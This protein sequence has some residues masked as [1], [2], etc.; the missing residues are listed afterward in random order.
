MSQT[1]EMIAD[2]PEAPATADPRPIRVGFVLHAMHVAGAEVLVVETIRRLGDRISPTVFCLDD[3]GA[4]GEGLRRDGVEVLELGRRPGRDLKVARR[5]AS[6]AL[7]RG[8][9]ILHAHQ[10]TPF[11]YSALAKLV[12]GRKAPRLIFTEHGRHVPDVVSNAR[13]LVNRLALRH[14]AD[15]VNAV[16]RFSAESLARV[17]GFDGRRIEVIENGIEPDRYKVPSDRA[18]WKRRLGFDPA[19]RLV[20]CVA[21]F[22]PVKGHETLLRG[23]A[24]AS[25]GRGDV[26]L[27]LA[28][29]G[30]LRGELEG[31]VSGLGLGGRVHFLGVRRDVPELLKASDLFAMTSLC[32]AASLT[33]LEAMAVGLPVVVTDVGGNPEIVRDE[34][35]GLLVPSGDV[36][37]TANALGRLLDQPDEA[38]SMGAN[39]RARVLDHYDLGRT[40]ERYGRLYEGLRRPTRHNQPRVAVGVGR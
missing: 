30:P 28:G 31:L 24:E 17:D 22:H 6:A 21:R 32:E 20:A 25:A 10:Y 23:F 34:V 18:A 36:G 5:L 12:A 1:S 38:A 29:D 26:D 33:I 15:A 11:F 37:A 35:D 2:L 40:V 27:L 16:C 7:E 8:V 14:L 19:R 4:L 39:G 9:E 13:R 3:V